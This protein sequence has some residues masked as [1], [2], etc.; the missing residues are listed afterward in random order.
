M[1]LTIVIPVY[2]VEKYISKCLESCLNQDISPEDYEIIVVNDGTADCSVA[3][4]EDYMK[5]HG[6]VRL[7]NRENGGLSVA[8]N[9]GLKAATGDYV[10]FVDSDDWIEPNCL[11]EITDIACKENLDVLCF[12]LQLAFPDGHLEKYVN[13][14]EKTRIVYRGIEFICKK[15]MPPAAWCAL[16][17]R[18][19][20]EE[21]SLNFYEGILHEDQ[22]FTPRA[23]CLAERITYVDKVIYNY[24]QRDGSI[25]KGAHSERKCRDLLTVADSLY[26]F[27]QTILKDIAQDAYYVMLSN[28]YFAF[29][30]SL[31]HY[32]KAFFEL[33]TYK[34]KP[35]YPLMI[36]PLLSTKDKWKY[37]LMNFS[38]RLYLKIYNLK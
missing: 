23:Y 20:L 21:H 17:K 33:K 3:I 31:A 35:Y 32:N 1:K 9:T 25:M 11:K 37:R 16:Y 27:S 34:T 29:S 26:D 24:N 10:W 4:V 22:E 30:Q 15:K 6:N 19:F 36:N 13:N 14:N 2:N 12:N 8:R 5:E 18:T 28:V 7:V 38:L